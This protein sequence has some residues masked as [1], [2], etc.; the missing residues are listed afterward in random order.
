[1][2]CT[3]PA[4]RPCAIWSLPAPATRSCRC[5][6]S[7]KTSASKI[8]SV[9]GGWRARIRAEPSCW[10]AATAFR[11]NARWKSS[12]SSSARTCHGSP[13]SGRRFQPRRLRQVN[14]G[15]K[16]DH[17][18]LGSRLEYAEP[19]ADVLDVGL[20]EAV[21]IVVKRQAPARPP[22]AHEVGGKARKERRL[23]LRLD[24]DFVEMIGVAR[25]K[26]VFETG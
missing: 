4:S 24:R 13:W 15:I 6:P 10:F 9:T 19:E 23:P 11:A 22:R 3:L 14:E 7:T 12:P 21:S 2:K 18:L 26:R 8:S 20:V 16:A 17:V 1:M 5:S 25:V